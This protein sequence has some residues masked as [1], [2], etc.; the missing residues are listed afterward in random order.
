[1][2][3]L[4]IKQGNSPFKFDNSV[5]LKTLD[6]GITQ[7]VFGPLLVNTDLSINIDEGSKNYG[8]FFNTRHS[9]FWLKRAY[10]V[11]LFYLPYLG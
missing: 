8:D 10:D 5:D 3:G 1:M 11:G 7:Q 6:L 9:I 4:T 2:P